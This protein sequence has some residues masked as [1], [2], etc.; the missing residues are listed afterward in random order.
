MVESGGAI[1]V[2]PAPWLVAAAIPIALMIDWLWGEPPARWH[3]VVWMGAYLQRAGAWAAPPVEAPAHAQ[4]WAG[5]RGALAWVAGAVACVVLAL[6]LQTLVAA[7]PVAVQAVLCGVLLKP[8]LAWRML[9]D[10]VAAVEAALGVSLQAG[11]QQVARLVSR[12]VSA[13]DEG[14]VRQAAIATLA[15]NL[16][17]SVVAPLCW[18]W[19]AGLPGVVLYRYANTAD[20]MWGYRGERGGRVWTRAGCWAAR[21]DDVLSWWPARATAMLLWL[22]APQRLPWRAWRASVLATPSPNGGWPMGT[23]ACLLG[24]VL[25]KRGVYTL[26][27]QGVIP[28][29]THMRRALVVARR[30]VL[31][32][33]VGAAFG[34]MAAVTAG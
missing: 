3:P 1:G 14:E 19:L 17:D 24:V 5:V 8:L 27:P 22:A 32:V 13:L 6:G 23:M 34:A 2:P 10:E 21:A 7:L 9:H 28:A 29:A 30:A 31:A 12:D 20:A 4:R 11:R 25:G 26:N 15:E 16:N 33:A 18:W